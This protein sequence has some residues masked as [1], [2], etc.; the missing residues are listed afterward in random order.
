MIKY[1][2]LYTHLKHT[3]SEFNLLDNH[4]MQCPTTTALA[5]SLSTPVLCV[6]LSTV[7]MMPTL[8]FDT[9]GT[10]RPKFV[11]VPHGFRCLHLARHIKI[12]HCVRRTII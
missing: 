7:N 10:A 2:H 3:I 8:G 9:A 1:T 11:N 6:T 4:S 12:L 5:A